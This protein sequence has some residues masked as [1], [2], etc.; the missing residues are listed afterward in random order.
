MLWTS[1]TP[2]ALHYQHRCNRDR[3]A[4]AEQTL[5]LPPTW[6]PAALEP[7]TNTVTV[8]LVLPFVQILW[9]HSHWNGFKST[10]PFFFV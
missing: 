9:K 7:Q 4:P 1:R 6:S 5:Q 2:A 3:L 10:N 8:I